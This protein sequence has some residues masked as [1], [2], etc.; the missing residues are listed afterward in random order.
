VPELYAR[1]EEYELREQYIVEQYWPN[2][3]TAD[4]LRAILSGYLAAQAMQYDVDRAK[5]IERLWQM[6]SGTYNP[7]A[8]NNSGRPGK[9]EINR[10]FG[11]G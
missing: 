2:G 10:V 6:L 1:F 3:H 4:N 8:T 11:V 5:Q 9:D 7:T